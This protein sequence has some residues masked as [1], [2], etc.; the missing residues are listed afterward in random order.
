MIVQVGA[1]S[2]SVQVQSS[3]LGRA[4]AAATAAAASQAA[5][6]AS[7][8][9]AASTL[10]GAALKANNLSD[11]AS[12]VTARTNLGGTA[13]GVSVFTAASAAAA[14]TAIGAV[15]GTDVQAYDAD[16]TTWAGITPGTGVGAALAVAIGSAGAPVLFNGAGGTP[17]S[18]TLTNA[19]A[20][21]VAGITSST[22]TALGVGSLEL[23]HATDT[24]LS[25]SSA[26]NVAVEGN[27]IYRAGGTDVPVA[28]GGTGSSTAA[29]ARTALAVVGLADLA[30]STGAALVGSIASE[31]GSTARTVQAKLDDIFDVRDLG[32]IV[33]GTTD[34]TSALVTKLTA[35]GAASFRGYINVPYG[36]KFV[37]ATVWAAIPTGI[38]LVDESSINFGQPPGYRNRKR[39][40]IGGDTA[41]DDYADVIG[42]PHHAAL[43]LLNT[44]TSGTSQGDERFGSI[45]QAVGIDQNNDF[46]T[47]QQLLFS[48]SSSGNSWATR[49]QLY[50]PYDIAIAN[51]YNWVTATVY[52]AG[53]MCRSDGGKIYV[54]AAGGT[55]GGTAPTGT[56]ASISDGGVTWAYRA[57]GFT[58][59][60][61]FLEAK[62]NGSLTMAS[63][64]AETIRMS[65]LSNGNG[66]YAEFDPALARM[67]M[68]H[69]GLG[70][71]IFEVDNTIGLRPAISM[72]DYW[73]AVTG[74]TPTAPATGAGKVT[75]GGA[76]NMTGMTPPTG[77]TN[78]TVTLR[79]DD[80]N[81]TV[82]HGLGADQWRLK[83]GVNATPGV[84]HF[85]TF[86][87][88]VGG[89]G[90]VWL[91]FSRSF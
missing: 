88:D 61:V 63:P 3:G 39:I 82:I 47:G 56:G 74:A 20:L 35:L 10:A 83:G 41:S 70:S 71:P 4:T 48:E 65:Q 25:R 29:D 36:T 66:W 30:A 23:G 44:G 80:A 21:P 19:T 64:L 1:Q 54:T 33:D 79:F 81:T 16:L 34:Q 28:D 13:V 31:T 55:S 17:S 76:T 58:V 18:M 24:T 37:P 42:S 12:I 22:S 27:L 11:L 90:G 60:S 78:L 69:I 40:V 9:S 87:M 49:L 50:T 45:L 5:A 67:T 77:R 91:E 46:I 59:E 53:A 32:I 14:R 85:M 57:A 43:F 6:A 73:V 8:A 86:K 51:P 7:A 38:T 2:V 72:G 15:I 52:A 75:N 62:D 89:F 68:Y 26:G 84:G